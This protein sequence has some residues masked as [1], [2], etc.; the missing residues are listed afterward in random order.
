TGSAPAATSAAP[1]GTPRSTSIPACSSS[2]PSVGSSSTR[3]NRSSRQHRTSTTS[4]PVRDLPEFL[5]KLPSQRL[6]KPPQLFHFQ[7]QP[8]RG[9]TEAAS[10]QQLRDHQKVFHRSAVADEFGNP[11]GS[12]L[13]GSY[14]PAAV[15]AECRPADRFA[16]RVAQR[17]CH[18]LAG[19]RR[20]HAHTVV[21]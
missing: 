6:P 7:R 15:C 9:G 18:R 20:P 16:A 4:L 19:A 10:R 8:A 12:V 11:G 3:R 14:Q 1:N 5:G 17:R 21:V 2:V 13:T